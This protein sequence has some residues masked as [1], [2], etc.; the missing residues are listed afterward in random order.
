[1]ADVDRRLGPGCDPV[2]RVYRCDRSVCQ[3][4]GNEQRTRSEEGSIP[5]ARSS[6]RVG[7]VAVQGWPR[8]PSRL[9]PDPGVRRSG[10]GG[11]V[12]Y[13]PHLGRLIR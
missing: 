8:R 9:R 2:A 11:Q 3:R 7:S 4:T 13:T 6:W 5:N 1:M 12:V 10:D